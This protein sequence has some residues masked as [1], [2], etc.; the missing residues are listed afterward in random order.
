MSYLSKFRTRMTTLSVSASL[1]W[2]N[3]TDTQRKL[4]VTIGFVGIGAV[5]IFLLGLWLG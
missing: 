4:Y 1:R 2:A 3:L 5:A